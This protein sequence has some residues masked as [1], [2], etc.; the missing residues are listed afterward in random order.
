MPITTALFC[1]IVGVTD[2]DT[3]KAVCEGQQVK[4]RLAEIDAPKRISLG[5][6]EASRRYQNCVSRNE[7]KSGHPRQTVTVELL[8]V[9]SARVLT[10]IWHRSVQAWRGPTRNI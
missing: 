8:L 2:G 1:L 5:D 10:P 6:S 4:I 9:L 3:I 7:P